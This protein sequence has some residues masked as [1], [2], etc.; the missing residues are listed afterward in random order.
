M[1]QRR[2]AAL[3]AALAAARAAT[4]ATAVAKGLRASSAAIGALRLFAAAP[5]VNAFDERPRRIIRLGLNRRRRVEVGRLALDPVPAL[6]NEAIDHDLVEGGLDR[7]SLDHL[8]GG[9]VGDFIDLAVGEEGDETNW[10]SSLGH[11]VTRNRLVHYWGQPYWL[12]YTRQGDNK[13]NMAEAQTQRGGQV[14][15]HGY[16]RSCHVTS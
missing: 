12:G 9:L 13:Q 4:F 1:R 3:A 6:A 5:A 16:M 14:S 10:F 2:A 15:M 8:A 7:R 11:V